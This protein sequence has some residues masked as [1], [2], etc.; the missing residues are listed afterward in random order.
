[1][2][3]RGI[4]KILEE[5]RA[6]LLAEA[7]PV[8]LTYIQFQTM[9]T[10]QQMGWAGVWEDITSRFAGQFLRAYGSNTSGCNS[11]AYT[12]D[13]VTVQGESLPNITASFSLWNNSQGNNYLENMSGAIYKI[14]DDG[15][16][17]N[18]MQYSGTQ[19]KKRNYGISASASNAI[20]KNDAHVT[21]YNSA[22]RIWQKTGN[23]TGGVQTY[24]GVYLH[25]EVA[26]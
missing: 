26:A 12:D 13:R 20:Y 5:F 6:R 16:S 3:Y 11:G 2:M 4:K 7:V 14:N 15:P 24:S 17:G 19:R 9:K 10:P 8:G 21:P 22:I 1:M 18:T 25:M 23:L